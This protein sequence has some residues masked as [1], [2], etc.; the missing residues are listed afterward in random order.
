M[1]KKTS[2]KFTLLTIFIGFILVF[3]IATIVS[4]I[5]ISQVLEGFG[6]PDILIY[7]KTLVFLFIFIM[8]LVWKNNQNVNLTRLV[9]QVLLYLGLFT[10]VLYFASLYLY[11][12]VLISQ[13]ADSIR[14]NILYGNPYLIFDFSAKNYKTLSYITTIFGGFNSEMILLAEIAILEIF[15][16]QSGRYEVQE[17]KTHSYDV[18]LY[19]GSIPVLLILLTVSSFLSINIFTFTYDIFS[20]VE[21]AISIFAFM[22]IVTAIIPAFKLNKTRGLPVTKSFF[23]GTYKLL[24]IIAILGFISF[25]ALFVINNIYL[26]LD[27]GSYRIIATFV[28]LII[29][30]LLFIKIFRKVRLENK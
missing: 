18:F 22:L 17:E 8:L 7:T 14:N 4:N 27:R 20:S 3:D 28:S 5:F 23:S 13:T 10:I 15:C 6:L 9:F 16:I 1:L 30:A 19:D 11:K 24:M 26:G 21:M 12:Y 2:N 29:S 25:G